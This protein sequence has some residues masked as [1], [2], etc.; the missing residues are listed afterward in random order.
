MPINRLRFLIVDSSA[1]TRRILHKLLREIGPVH[2]DEAADGR[3][4]LGWLNSERCDFVIA[5]AHLPLLDGF[6]LIRALRRDPALQ[7]LPALLV[8]KEASKDHVV[9]AARVGASGYIVRPL[10]RASLED[11]VLTILGLPA[12][13]PSR[14]HDVQAHSRPAR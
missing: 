7:A 1:T 14:R 9:R 4:A 3:T 8:T 11:K 12:R 10:T 6:E 13:P 2:V 5:E